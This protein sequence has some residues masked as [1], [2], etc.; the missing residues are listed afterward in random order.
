MNARLQL[1][2]S[3]IFA[4]AAGAC[5]LGG[6]ATTVRAP[7]VNKEHPASPHAASGAPAPAGFPLLAPVSP[8]PASEVKPA[9][10][11]ED[12]SAHHHHDS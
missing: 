9:N 6:C 10:A 8:S 7:A 4:L 1:L 5:V 11:G 2:R 12:V 3:R